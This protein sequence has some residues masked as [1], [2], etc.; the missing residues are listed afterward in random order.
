LTDCGTGDG[1]LSLL[2]K[3]EVDFLRVPPE[4]TRELIDR[5]LDRELVLSLHRIARGMGARTIADQVDTAAIVDTLR[6]IGIDF[7]QG[8]ALQ[9]AMPLE[10]H[11]PSAVSPASIQVA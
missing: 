6:S 11:R 2:R 1:S 4:F 8:S 3:I 5:P 9:S 7:A 10:L